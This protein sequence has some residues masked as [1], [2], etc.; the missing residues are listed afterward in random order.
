MDTA[1]HPAPL[2]RLDY[3]RRPSAAPSR[4]IIS[5]DHAPASAHRSS[6]PHLTPDLSSSSPAGDGHTRSSSITYARDSLANHN[7][8]SQ[9]TN[10]SSASLNRRTSFPKRYSVGNSG[11]L[12]ACI[13]K[14]KRNQSPASLHSPDIPRSSDSAQPS[15]LAIN[16]SHNLVASPSPSTA[17]P[18]TP[19][20]S[21]LKTPSTAPSTA[22]LEPDRFQK[23][24]PARPRAVSRTKTAPSANGAGAPPYLTAL[25]AQRPSTSDAPSPF[26]GD[27][28]AMETERRSRS[29][30]HSRSRDAGSG[31]RSR[32]RSAGEKQPSQKAMLSKALQKANSAVL[33]DNAQDFDG[34]ME[35]YRE[36]CTLLGHV[37]SRS[38]GDEDKRKLEAIRNTYTNRIKELNTMPSHLRVDH[39]K[40]LPARPDSQDSLGAET[41]MAVIETATVTHIINNDTSVNE[42][43]NRQ[44]LAANHLPPRRESLRLPPNPKTTHL[45]SF[46]SQP[47]ILA[48]AAVLQPPGPLSYAPPPL[49]PRR[50]RSPTSP[51]RHEPPNPAPTLL[52][53]PGLLPPPN[54][55]HSRSPSTESISWLDTIDE[56]G[57]SSASSVHSRSS[58]HGLRRKRIRPASGATEAEF[59][60]ALDAAVEAAYDDGLEPAP[61]EEAVRPDLLSNARRNVE[62]AKERV[63]EAEREAA[64]QSAKDRERRRQAERPTNHSR[65]DSVELEYGDE[66][67]AEEERMLEEMTRDYIMDDFEFDL[68]S[69]SALPRQSDSSGFS[70][71][72]WGSSVGSLP[73]TGATSLRTLSEAPSLPA[74]PAKLQSKSAPPPHPP[75]TSALPPPPPPL[76]VVSAPPLHQPP[77][78]APPRP[79][80]ANGLSSQGVRGR[81]LSGQNHKQLKIETVQRPS[82]SSHAP[83]SQPPLMPPP[84]VPSGDSLSAPPKTAPTFPPM[85]PSMLVRPPATAMPLDMRRGYSPVPDA[86][87]S[88]NLRSP[89]PAFS[90]LTKTLSQESDQ[91]LPRSGSPGRLMLDKKTSGG[92]MLRK[93]FS[94]SSLK[95]R[96][97]SVSSPEGSEISPS[98]PMSTGFSASSS[99]HRS[100][101]PTPSV[102]ALPLTSHVIPSISIG[103][104]Y[105]FEN[106][107]QPSAAPGSPTN[108]TEGPPV[109]LEP[110]PSEPSLRPFW[111]M[112]CMYQTLAHPKGGYLSN[113]LFVPRE[114]WYAKVTKIKGLEEKVSSCDLL[115]AALSK[116]DAVDT[117]DADAVLDEMQ[118]L[119]HVLDTVQ[120]ALTKKLGSDVGSSN[121]GS[122]F[123]DGPSETQSQISSL[124]GTIISKSTSTTSKSSYLSWRRL[125]SK[126]SGAGLTGSFT[127]TSTGSSRDTGR[128]TPFMATLPMAANSLPHRGKIKR[129]NPGSLQFAGPNANYMSAIAKLCDA[130]QAL[131]RIARQV[132]DPGLRH[133]SSTQVGLELSTRHA[134][135]FF[136]FYVCR[137]LLSDLGLLVDKYL[138]RGTEWVNI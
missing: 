84:R 30:G 120:V 41:E 18:M 109:P 13:S 131:D 77:L 110:C 31:G 38:A 101:T 92:G 48:S 21:A 86:S 81:R 4:S 1:S 102:P 51:V 121:A 27:R 7:R 98:T 73:T 126:Q 93:N 26:R 19:L 9:S 33:L 67:A 37:M 130:V 34:A 10:S 22:P 123:K 99:L 113:K 72:T 104:L 132:E 43:G 25:S 96:N 118:A 71:R 45:E 111:L 2:S 53:V 36:A 12:A 62:L 63:R 76:N 135:D 112:R 5:L 125:R 129:G 108:A 133:S 124:D 66:E 3:H 107:P 24:S 28:L 85:T 6:N 128:E 42:P 117:Y 64:I 82:T 100:K 58:N 91:G 106:H 122:S 79:P 105:L 57:G 97:F 136:A 47:A 114:A 116:L 11:P 68:Q 54:F 137:F 88:E 80:S 119:E 29:R 83:V 46:Y 138:K 115:T 78:A 74:I 50:P 23:F 17:T 32:D 16:L 56:S 15:R 69:K 52:P 94:S 49:S 8:W 134:A 65:D 70:G 127:S 35:A 40:A 90:G 14:G 39:N 44:S 95:N 87:S 59:D 75:P 89:S 60:A 55:G 61:E 20:T 103:G